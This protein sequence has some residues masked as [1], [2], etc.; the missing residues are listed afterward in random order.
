M[1]DYASPEVAK[2][3]ETLIERELETI[4]NEKARELAKN[5]VKQIKTEGKRDF[6]F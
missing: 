3:G 1:A 4:P 5:Y 2:A 6:R